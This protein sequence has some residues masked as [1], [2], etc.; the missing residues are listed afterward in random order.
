MFIRL[1]MNEML[2]DAFHA[3]KDL[4]KLCI[5]DGPLSMA[6]CRVGIVGSGDDTWVIWKT[7]CLTQEI[8]LEL[9]FDASRK[10]ESEMTFADTYRSDQ[11]VWLGCISQRE[12]R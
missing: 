11:N 1:P 7:R 5:E 8:V 3:A 2:P 6:A 12:G 4:A 9:G 10:S